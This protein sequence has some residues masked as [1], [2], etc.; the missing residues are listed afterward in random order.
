MNNGID[1]NNVLA[2]TGVRATT[3][4]QM[5]VMKR[6][7]TPTDVIGYVLGTQWLSYDPANPSVATQF[8]LSSVAQSIATWVPLN[9]GGDRQTL[10]DHSVALGIG[11]PGLGSVGPSSNSGYVLTSNGSSSDPSFQ[12]PAA[13]SVSITGDT[14]GAL[15]G[16]AF[17][18]TGGS[19]GLTFAG[20]T[21]TETLGGTL[22][23]GNGGTGVATMTTAYAPVCAGTTATGHL[24]VASTGMSNSG[25]VLTSTGSS[26]LPTWQAA[27]GGTGFSA[28]NVQ[29]FD[30][31]GTTTY[32]PTSGMAYAIVECIGG[33]GGGAGVPIPSSTALSGAGGGGG[34]YCRKNITAAAIG[35]SKTVVIGASGS[36]GTA[37]TDGSSGG[38]TTF[39]AILTA[40][41]GAGGVSPAV[42]TGYECLGGNGGSATGGDINIAGQPGMASLSLSSGSLTSF[43]GAGASGIYGS[44]G[45]A[46]SATS[47]G[48]GN[49]GLGYGAG[50][51]GGATV[52]SSGTSKNGGAGSSGAIIITEYIA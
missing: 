11:T 24:Q 15:I 23:V 13:S 36:G 37:G 19:T 40:H 25:W 46:V 1:G 50:G 8:V 4:P 38:D 6:D 14:G 34:A 5:I 16:D 17:T 20:A 41:G 31:P 9:E 26:S 47:P 49:A 21:T 27:G 18:F 2:Y 51:S 30:T 32:T 10:P 42:G 52:G 7:P 39:G 43:G 35:A 12:A 3:P 48:N 28:I 22:I 44:G 29:V 33:G 45:N